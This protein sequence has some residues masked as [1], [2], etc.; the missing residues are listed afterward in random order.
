MRLCTSWF[1]V[2]HHA[3]GC[4][5]QNRVLAKQTFFFKALQL[6]AKNASFIQP[7]TENLFHKIARNRIMQ[8]RKAH[9]SAKWSLG[10]IAQST[11]YSWKNVAQGKQ[12]FL[13]SS[14]NVLRME[15]LPSPLRKSKKKPWQN[16]M[17]IINKGNQVF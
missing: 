5:L 6:Y 7:F 8:K 10:M 17:Y 15:T 4:T 16:A 14:A 2:C 9:F 1:A 12:I 13:L 11:I 3:S